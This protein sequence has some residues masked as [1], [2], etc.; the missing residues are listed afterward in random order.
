MVI[1]V[2]TSVA[3]SG[4]VWGRTGPG[5]MAAFRDSGTMSAYSQLQ[6]FT[7]SG[8][9]CHH[10]L[11]RTLQPMTDIT[12]KIKF[13]LP[14]LQLVPVGWGSL[15]RVRAKSLGRARGNSDKRQQQ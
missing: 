14:V 6:D 7:W 15:S 2:Y 11:Q 1:H 9:F 8:S 3:V 12:P 10:F 4:R 13:L 5:Y